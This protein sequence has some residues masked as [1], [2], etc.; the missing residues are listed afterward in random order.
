ML[1][2]PGRAPGG[3]P[4]VLYS[5]CVPVLALRVLFIGPE[6]CPSPPALFEPKNDREPVRADP[7]RVMRAPLAAAGHFIA[8]AFAEH[9]DRV[10]AARGALD[11]EPASVVCG[12]DFA[13]SCF[14]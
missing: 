10:G 2:R 6:A 9:P 7:S 5:L 12:R 13:E 4:N 3:H 11:L 8:V 14:C 1:S